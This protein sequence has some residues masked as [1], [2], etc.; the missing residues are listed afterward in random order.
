MRTL[1]GDPCPISRRGLEIYTETL[2]MHRRRTRPTAKPRTCTRRRARG[3][4]RRRFFRVG[5]EGATVDERQI[6]ALAAAPVANAALHA[7]ALE[8]A[9]ALE[10]ENVA[11][12]EMPTRQP[13]QPGPKAE[14][15]SASITARL[16][17]SPRLP[18]P[19]SSRMSVV[20]LMKRTMRT[21]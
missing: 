9:C 10:D 1:L 6:H 3:V 4:S 20:I 13:R 21:T 2:Q 18:A 14:A 16:P 5:V 17:P 11:A 19:R 15:S 8:E 7:N 12:G